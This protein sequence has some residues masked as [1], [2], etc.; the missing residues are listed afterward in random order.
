MRAAYL[1]GVDARK[2]PGWRVLNV[3]LGGSSRKAAHAQA[4]VHVAACHLQRYADM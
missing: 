3:G 1:H 2:S 4:E